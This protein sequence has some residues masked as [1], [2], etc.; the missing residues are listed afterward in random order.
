MRHHQ[1]A[2]ALLLS[3]LLGNASAAA[4]I[5]LGVLNNTTLHFGNTFSI[6]QSF[7]VGSAFNDVYL[8]DIVQPAM[9]TGAAVTINLSLPLF[10]APFFELSDLM[11]QITAP[12][13]QNTIAS[14]V[15]T[16]R[17]DTTLVLST[18]LASANDYQFIV[19]GKVTGS[20]GG[21]Y[22]G[23][24]Q[25]QSTVLPPTSSPIPEASSYAFLGL[26]LGLVG[27]LARRRG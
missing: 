12:D 1:L 27:M 24:L 7:P 22:A 23:V 2:L 10:P 8:F 16:S 17:S 5:D 3:G 15:Q 11:I 25:A 18:A 14:D 26:G 13:G 9:V 6:D 19:S 21:S 20:L 4:P